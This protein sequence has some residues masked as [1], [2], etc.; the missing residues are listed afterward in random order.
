V[1]SGN[2]S[3]ATDYEIATSEFATRTSLE[4]ARDRVM[5]LV[6]DDIRNQLALGLRQR[7]NAAR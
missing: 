3:F 7:E 4:N 1:L 2:S 5:E 6:A